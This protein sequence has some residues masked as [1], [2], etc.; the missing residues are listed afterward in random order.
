MVSWLKRLD[1][2][3]YF[4]TSA[5]ALAGADAISTATRL[6][7]VPWIVIT[8][9]SLAV[10]NAP[11]QQQ[12]H[13]SVIWALVVVLLVSLAALVASQM[14][15]APIVRLT[16]V[17]DQVAKGELAT[18]AQVETADEI[19]ALAATFNVMTDELS[20]TLMGLE[21][22]V[23]E[24]TRGIEL[25]ADISRRL[26]IILDPAQL[27]SEVVE[28]LQ[29]A[30][31]YY[32]VQIYLFDEERSNLIMMGGTGEAGKIMLERG[33]K[34]ARGQGLVGHACETGSVV[35]V[36]DTHQNPQWVPN[37]LLPDTNAEIAVPI[38]L[39]D[40]VL[41]ALDVQQQEIGGLGQ[42]D[43]D[44]LLAIANQVAIALRNARQFAET[45]QSIAHQTRINTIIQQIQDTTS[46]ESALQVAAR[47]IG[48]ALNAQRTKAQL[49]LGQDG[50]RE[51]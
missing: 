37:E 1:Q 29:F 24:R 22:R 5:A 14:L 4:T 8:R 48:R 15:T 34:L 35:L 31:D 11:A 3:Q 50:D 26:S 13:L 19:G 25:S 45:Q 12:F 10:A 51:N 16:K 30:F 20:R 47:E 32:H 17:A 44:L 9:Q 6:Q 42:Q 18:R 43:A 41:G 38:I 39:G 21:K 27:V 33:H 2:Q 36:Q 40:Q 46:V 7:N 23:S 28:L 49:G